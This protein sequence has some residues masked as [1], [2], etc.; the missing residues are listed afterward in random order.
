[1]MDYIK[2]NMYWLTG[3]LVAALVVM[4]LFSLYYK[5][6]YTI[7]RIAFVLF[8]LWDFYKYRKF[9]IPKLDKNLV[10]GIILFYGT[11]LGVAIASGKFSNLVE[12]CNYIEHIL[13]LFMLFYL[14][15][16]VDIK[17][18]MING[19]I[20]IMG[21]G[22]IASMFQFTLL[23]ISRPFGLLK[24]PNTWALASAMV[25]PVFLFGVHKYR[26]N[27]KI[28]YCIISGLTFIGIL[29]AQSRGIW[30]AMV[31][32]SM[33]FGFYF[34]Y[35]KN[36]KVFYTICGLV[37]LGVCFLTAFSDLWISIFSRGYD[38]ERLYVYQSA[39]N[40]W[41]DHPF[42]GVGLGM[43]EEVYLS[44][45]KLPIARESL[46]HA[47]NIYLH[48]LS[49]TGIVG[50]ISFILFLTFLIRS[51][52][53]EKNNYW[54]VGIYGIM[55]FLIQEIFDASFTIKYCSR[56]FWLCI[57]LYKINAFQDT[58]VKESSAAESKF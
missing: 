56:V 39:Y 6:S 58:K 11:L 47:H 29:M 44:E 57:A 4:S 17:K 45:Y 14:N 1:M 42:I 15:E 49:A 2:K 55:I 22:F 32:S 10:I 50:F 51:M 18:G 43:W 19:L 5:P 23:D 16:I 41:K 24:N 38:A 54:L 8:A 13:P 31:I 35:Y 12:S 34:L 21:I 52:T 27:R 20:V 3:N 33:L 53:N 25:L 28:L 36:K 40:M 26:D 48:V 37:L 46:F 9:R 30:L 7:G